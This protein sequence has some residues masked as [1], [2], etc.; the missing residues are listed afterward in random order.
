MDFADNTLSYTDFVAKEL[1]HFS[2]YDVHR[3]IPS[4]VD[5]FKPTQRKVTEATRS[6][7]TVAG[8]LFFGDL[9]VL[10]G[11]DSLTQLCGCSLRMIGLV[12]EWLQRLAGVWK[13][14]KTLSGFCCCFRFL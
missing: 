8:V 14:V 4:M 9:G 11:R 13:V 6:G 7:A 12:V 1:V 5:G 2:K 10:S 3:S